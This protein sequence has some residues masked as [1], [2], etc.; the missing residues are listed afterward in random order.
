MFGEL[1]PSSAGALAGALA[2]GQQRSKDPGEEAGPHG[3]LCTRGWGVPER[4]SSANGNANGI[5]G[6]NL[7]SINSGGVGV[8]HFTIKIY[9]WRAQD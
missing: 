5:Y 3:S 4:L 6:P 1:V 7:R 9:V 2:S 8:N